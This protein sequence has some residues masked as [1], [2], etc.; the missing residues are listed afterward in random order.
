MEPTV[1]CTG[2]NQVCSYTGTRTWSCGCEDGWSNTLPDGTDNIEC[3]ANV[4]DC[5]NNTACGDSGTCVD[6]D[7]GFVCICATGYEGPECVTQQDP[8]NEP[9]CINGG[10]CA[11]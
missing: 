5:L 8:C 3:T 7:N 11:S 2:V 4:D 6:L 10:S 9:I 1:K